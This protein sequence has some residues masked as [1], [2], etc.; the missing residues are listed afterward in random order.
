MTASVAKH[1]ARL[2]REGLRAIVVE[3]VEA[4]G[5]TPRGDDALMIVDA[6]EVSGTIGGGHLEF[7][8]I[9]VART[10]IAEG[11]GA[12]RQTIPLGPAMGQC[13]GGQ[14]TLAFTPFDEGLAARI[15]AELRTVAAEAPEVFAFGLGHTGRAFAKVMAGMPFRT[16]LVDDRPEAFRDLPENCRGWHLEDPEEAVAKAG[17]GAAFV[18]FT[19][20]HALDYRLA[21]ATLRRRD[22]A[23]VG[24]IGSATKRARFERWFLQRG[25][26]PSLLAE[27]VCPIGGDVVDKR[28]EVIALLAAAEI[29]KVFAAPRNDGLARQTLRNSQLRNLVDLP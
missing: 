10:M 25:G 17:A 15:A 21:D 11:L 29:A 14:V 28:P 23:Y 1:L 4:K 27:L 18:I 3:I 26:E 5:S 2:E 12:R 7:H 16:C 20:S 19:H 6:A 22:A 9:D 8:A 13:C 24:M